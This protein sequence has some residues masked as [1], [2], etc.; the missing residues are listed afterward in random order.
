MIT[1]RLDLHLLGVCD[2]GVGMEVNLAEVAAADVAALAPRRA[3]AAIECM[4]H[5]WYTHGARNVESESEEDSN[6]A[7]SG[8][9]DCAHRDVQNPA[10]DKMEDGQK[11]SRKRDTLQRHYPIVLLLIAAVRI[12]KA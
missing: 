3:R 5:T 11:M 7:K 4:V 6:E 1:G 10:L 2:V 9:A 12:M 8:W